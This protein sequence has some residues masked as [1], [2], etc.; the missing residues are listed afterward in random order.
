MIRPDGARFKC[1]ED[2]IQPY[3]FRQ[4]VFLAAGELRKL[5][6]Q[7]EEFCRSLAARLSI[8]LRLE[9]GLQMSRLQ[10]LTYQKFLDSLQNPTHL[11][12]FRADPLRGISILEL[13]VQLGITIV[14]RLL[15]G[16]A[17]A[18][19]LERDLSDIEAALLDQAVQ[20]I[21]T[22]WSNQWRS[23]IELRPAVAGHESSGRFL[24][25]STNDTVMLVLAME[26]RLGDCHDTI[27]MAF[28][29][30]MLEPIMRKLNEDVDG[31]NDMDGD[32]KAP[33]RWNKRLD[34]IRIP[35]SA[36]WHSIDVTARQ[37]ARLRIGEVIPLGEDFSDKIRIN[38]ANMP[39]FVGRLGTQDKKWAVELTEVI[40][41]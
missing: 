30:Y 16:P 26:A 13:P 10:T 41:T 3:D 29:C 36:S 27:Q 6:M 39:K 17:R 33:I 25:T 1:P 2:T 34:D 32:I 19:N 18:T 11:T 5:R 40:K 8:Y 4:P 35:V 21:L 9:F 12:L 28:P 38:L 7:Q 31:P 20:I 14:D 22:E 37:L 24:Q 23:L 15:G